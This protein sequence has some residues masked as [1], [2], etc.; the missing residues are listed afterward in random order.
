MRSSVCAGAVTTLRFLPGPDLPAAGL[1]ASG[2]AVSAPGSAPPSTSLFQASNWRIHANCRS[3]S[4]EAATWP[5]L[6]PA[7]L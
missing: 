4:L 5:P 3:Y 2:L 6:A 1:A 7:S